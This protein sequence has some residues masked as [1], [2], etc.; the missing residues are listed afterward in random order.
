MDRSSFLSA[1]IGATPVLAML[2]ALAA[3]KSPREVWWIHR[4]RDSGEHPFAEEVRTR[5]KALPHANGH[6]RYSAPGP[7]DRPGVD[8]D[9]PGRLGTP[10]LEELGV[11]R[12]AD[13]Y[14]CGPAAFMT[15]LPAGLAS[16][17]VT[18]DRIHTP[19]CSERAR[20]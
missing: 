11:P 15:D 17:G 9:A 8:F 16:W 6:I 18:A 1:G 2:H 3:V 13:F 12:G 14:L 10:V 19:S 7:G 4:A 20:P 5:L